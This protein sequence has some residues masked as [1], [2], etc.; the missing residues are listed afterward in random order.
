MSACWAI[1]IKGPCSIRKDSIPARS[2]RSSGPAAIGKRPA[3]RP[4]G[5]DAGISS[6][7]CRGPTRRASC[8]SSTARPATRLN[9]YV[10]PE[11]IYN[12]RKL[13]KI[14]ALI[15]HYAFKAIPTCRAYLPRASSSISPEELNYEYRLA[16][17]K[18][19]DQR[20]LG[21][22]AARW[23][24]SGVLRDL[25]RRSRPVPPRRISFGTDDCKNLRYPELDNFLG[26][27]LRDGR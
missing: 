9:E 1:T 5:S 6:A 10:F 22:P 8:C 26:D 16:D 18:V 27:R 14:F 7:S 19:D 2:G 4:N 3:R 12:R 25:R 15:Q 11:D 20:R 17:E 23:Q 24:P 21:R 13:E